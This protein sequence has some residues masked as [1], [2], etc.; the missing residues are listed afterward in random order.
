MHRSFGMAFA[1]NWHVKCLVEADDIRL[2]N[3]AETLN[4]SILPDPLSYPTWSCWWNQTW[5]CSNR[6]TVFSVVCLLLLLVVCF[7]HSAHN[8][9]YH[10]HRLGLP[11][12]P[13]AMFANDPPLTENRQSHLAKSRLSFRYVWWRVYNCNLD[14]TKMKGTITAVVRRIWEWIA[15]MQDVSAYSRP[16]QLIRTLVSGSPKGLVDFRNSL[17]CSTSALDRSWWPL[18]LNL[19]ASL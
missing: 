16:S 6:P 3:T 15:I 13:Q 18:M 7:L 10:H 19:S 12:P 17:L 2:A 11:S 5:N 14:L 9:L 8:H 4:D 1:A